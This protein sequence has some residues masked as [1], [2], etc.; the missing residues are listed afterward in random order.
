MILADLEIQGRLRK[1]IM[2]APKNGFFYVLDRQTGELISAKNFVQVTWASHVDPDS[3]RP[4]ETEAARFDTGP[5]LALPSPFGAHNWHP[6]SFSPNTGLVYIPAQEV[7]FVFGKDENFEYAPGYWNTGVDASLAALPEDAE[8]ASQVAAMIKGRIIAWDPVAQEEIF[9]VEHQRPWNGGMLSTA[10][11]LLFQGTPEGSFAAYS[12]DKG[13]RLWRFE[14]QTGIVAAP[15]SYEIDGIQYVA[16][17]AGWGGSYPLFLGAASPPLETEPVNQ[18]L[19]FRLDG[20]EQLPAMAPLS[21]ELP[22]PP[23]QQA[24][25]EVVTQGKYLFHNRCAMC[26]GESAV[27][28]GIIPDLRYLSEQSH[29][30]W[31]AIVLGGARSKNGMPGFGQLLSPEEADAIHAYVIARAQLAWDARRAEQGVKQ[32]EAGAR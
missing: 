3:G 9:H 31:Y 26:H 13:D 22:R 5:A 29:A 21:R 2:Q 30:E 4:V 1:V 11:N 25:E 6:M 23:G 24:G 14:A 18:L 17:M 20:K 10:G 15:I 27:S 16:V 32:Q 28:G 19:V 8:T 7:P 12:A